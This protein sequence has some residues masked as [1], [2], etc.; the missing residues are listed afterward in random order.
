MA[1][2]LAVHPLTPT[3]DM[4][5]ESDSRYGL[6]AL[7][8]IFL[9][10][11]FSSAA[12]SL[13][14]HVSI[15]VSSPPSLFSHR[16]SIRLLLQSLS[17][18]FEGQSEV[19]TPCTGYSSL[20]LCSVTRELAPSK[21]TELSSDSS[22]EACTLPIYSQLKI[23]L[24]GI[25]CMECYFQSSHSWLATAHYIAGHKRYWNPLFALCYRQIHLSG[26][27][28]DAMEL[29]VLLHTFSFSS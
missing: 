29:D 21:P 1:L 28:P 6:F 9:I 16:S 19:Y 24:S 11:A 12:Y 7:D 14:G 2:S 5:G 13:S 15:S 3:L 27:R 23:N 20:R 10:H 25:R 17:L 26:S 18:T 22:G 8:S 4:Y